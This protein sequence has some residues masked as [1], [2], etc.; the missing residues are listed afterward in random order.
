M[1]H[2]IRFNSYWFV[3]RADD[4]M[5][6]HQLVILKG[7]FWS[8]SVKN[9]SGCTRLEK[10][11]F[12]STLLPLDEWNFIQNLTFLWKCIIH[13]SRNNHIPFCNSKCFISKKHSLGPPIRIYFIPGK[14]ILKKIP[15]IFFLLSKVCCFLMRM[16]NCFQ[17]KCV[18]ADSKSALVSS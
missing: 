17:Q 8:L 11:F 4:R 9:E 2:R 6:E 10:V 5:M 3:R 13:Q 15:L 14:C 1:D 12:F 18:L 16:R 7:T